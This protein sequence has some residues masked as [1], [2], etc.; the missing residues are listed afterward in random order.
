MATAAAEAL[1]NGDGGSEESTAAAAD[2][3][4]SFPVDDAAVAPAA[5]DGGLP[6]AAKTAGRRTDGKG[7]VPT[8]AREQEEKSPPLRAA[9]PTVATVTG[10][11]DM[12]G[13][14]G[15]SALGLKRPTLCGDGATLF[16]G[17]CEGGRWKG[18][19]AAA[20]AAAMLL[21]RVG[22]SAVPKRVPLAALRALL[23]LPSKP[24]TTALRMEEEE[25]A[26]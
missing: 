10:D 5:V 15:G 12:R 11:R 24:P 19:S 16:V 14:G 26:A 8:R 18:S 25:W 22:A 2:G 7:A 6:P 9:P 20:V 17:C 4:F 13:C 3:F 23:V 21:L 1:P